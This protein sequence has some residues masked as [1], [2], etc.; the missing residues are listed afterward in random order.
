[1]KTKRIARVSV[2][3]NSFKLLEMARDQ[4]LMSLA[5]NIQTL[6]FRSDILDFNQ[7]FPAYLVLR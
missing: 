1:M 3:E 7:L 6:G 5:T 2:T 4:G